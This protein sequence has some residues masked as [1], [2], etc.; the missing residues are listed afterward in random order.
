MIEVHHLTHNFDAQVALDEVNLIL[1]PGE[2][3]VLQGPSGSGKTTLI[4]LIAGLDFP[5]Q[6]EILIDG[7]LASTPSWV[8]PPHRRGVGIVFQRSALWPHM[9]VAGNLRFVMNGLPTGEKNRQIERL[10][11]MAGIESLSNRLPG[12]LSGGEARRVALLRA[13]AATPKRLLLDEP[14]TNLDLELKTGMLELIRETQ[15]EY[16][17]TLLYVTHDLEE[18]RMIGG[19]VMYLENGRLRGEA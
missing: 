9:T 1:Q 8:M 11:H 14:L 6:G 10:L 4:R 18:A 17:P 13:L 2:I 15:S 12:Q 3:V 16:Q 19:R 5:T 7:Q